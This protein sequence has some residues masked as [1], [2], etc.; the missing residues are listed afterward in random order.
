MTDRAS[1]AGRDLDVPARVLA[2]GAHHDDVEFGCGATL[3]KWAAAGCEAHLLVLTDGSKGT[4]DADADGDALVETRRQEQKAAAAVLGLAGVIALDFVDGELESGLD[5]RA[6]V[7]E[8]VRRVA[9]DIVL[10]HDPWKRYRLHPDHRHA[11]WLTLDGIVA[12]RDPQFFPDQGLDPH[13]PA[14]ILLFEADVPNHVEDVAG[15]VDTKVDALLCHRSQ[16]RST[17]GIVEGAPDADRRRADFATRIHDEARQAG[18]DLGAAGPVE[19]FHL[20]DRV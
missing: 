1:A 7:C 5:G 2:V 6:A 4:W 13:R 14:A 3:A 18:R 12:A 20:V 19:A 10:G 17:M 9:P 16:W 11:G 8:V 15:F